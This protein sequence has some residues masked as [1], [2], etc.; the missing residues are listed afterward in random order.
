MADTSSAAAVSL[1]DDGDIA[2]SVDHRGQPALRSS[3]GGWRSAA[4]IISSNLITYLTGPLGQSTAAAA[5]NVN[6]WSGTGTLLPVVGAIVADSFLGRYTTIIVASVIYASGLG[7]LTLSAALTISNCRN[8]NSSVSPCSSSATKLQEILFFISLYMVAIGQGGHKPCAQAFGADQFDE[9]HSKERKDRS[10]FFN[11]WYCSTAI[12][13]NVAL[14]VVVYVQD[15]LSWAVGFAIPCFTML[16]SL[17]TFILGRSTYRFSIRRKEDGNP[18]LRIGRVIVRAVRRSCSS[19]SK[20]SGI[21]TSEEGKAY[22]LSNHSSQQFKFLNEALFM[23]GHGSMEDDEGGRLQVCSVSDV[24]ETKQM[25]RLFPIWVSSLGYAVVFIVSLVDEITGGRSSSS[26]WFD[27]DLNKAH[28]DYFYWLLA[29]L[30]GVWFVGF[31]CSAR[32]YVYRL[33]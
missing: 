12:G 17:V 13:I 4:F 1:L 5:E 31:L 16:A 8:S 32:T 28:L 10:S 7:L 25:L 9:L 3:S 19:S 26:S 11:W 24:E 14:L 30:S 33:K 2:G 20:E 18:F 22:L 6:A 23:P 29:V 15:N 21:V 27:D